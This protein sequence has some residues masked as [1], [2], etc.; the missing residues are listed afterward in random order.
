MPSPA[1]AVMVTVVEVLTGV[2]PMEKEVED[3]PGGTV[4]CVGTVAAPLLLLVRKTVVPEEG[5]T[6][7]RVSVFV[8]EVTPPAAFDEESARDLSDADFTVS[9]A[10]AEVPVALAVMVTRAVAATGDVVTLNVAEA[11]PAGMVTEA[12]TCA[13][14]ESLIA[15]DTMTPPVGAGEASVT[16]PFVDLP[17]LTDAGERVT[18]ETVTGAGLSVRV[19]VKVA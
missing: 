1:E 2:V 15:S 11:A 19:A 12:G 16:E 4:T 8:E 18:E 6:E 9:G 14:E 5:D 17:P 3:A 7:S 13:I 10:L